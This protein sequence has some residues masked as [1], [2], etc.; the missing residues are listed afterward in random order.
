MT[1]WE[2][3]RHVDLDGQG[4]SLQ[5]QGTHVSDSDYWLSRADIAVLGSAFGAGEYL[6]LCDMGNRFLRVNVGVRED[7]NGNIFPFKTGK[8]KRIDGVSA[9]LNALNRLIVMPEPKPS[10]YQSRGALVLTS[11]PQP[12][13]EGPT[14]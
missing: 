9:T 2:V 11:R 3:F 12:E 6:L 5:Y 10:V 8:K 13:P 14:A 1:T 4:G 7:K